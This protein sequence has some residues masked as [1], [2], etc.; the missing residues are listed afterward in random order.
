MNLIARNAENMVAPMA[1]TKITFESIS[2]RSG[3]FPTV[4]RANSR[5]QKVPAPLPAH[6]PIHR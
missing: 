6:S 4:D 3:T 1:L 5:K 2:S